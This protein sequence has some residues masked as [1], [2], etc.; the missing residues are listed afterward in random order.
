MTC[1]D[2]DR[3]LLTVTDDVYTPSAPPGVTEYITWAVY[4]YTLIRGDDAVQIRI[5]R[6]QIDAYTQA[7]D[8]SDDGGFFDRVMTALD[9]LG[10]AYSV[11]DTG[12]DNDA[13][14][15]RLIIQ[16]DVA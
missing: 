1:S 14:A 5:P 4:S 16:C 2:L 11:Q 8:A 7:A 3:K 15:M 12:Y 6:V 13:A 10:L 9:E